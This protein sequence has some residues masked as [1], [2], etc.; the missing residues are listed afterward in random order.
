MEDSCYY[1]YYY[2]NNCDMEIRIE[3]IGHDNLCTHEICPHCKSGDVDYFEKSKE[4]SN[5]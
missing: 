1:G 4:V 2:C 5:E 3:D